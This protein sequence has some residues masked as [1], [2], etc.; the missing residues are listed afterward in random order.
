MKKV[1]LSFVLGV[2]FCFGAQAADLSIVFD[3]GTTA[4]TMQAK[5][6]K[7]QNQIGDWMKADLVRV[8]GRYAKA[9]ISAKLA[10][11]KEDAQKSDL[12]M[13]KIVSYSAGSKAARM[14]VGYGAGGVKLDIHYELIVDGKSLMSKDDG[15][16]SGRDWRNAARKL[17]EN[18]AKA[19]SQELKK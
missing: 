4:D 19:V 12:L 11:K 10:D 16:Y 3:N 13:V 14:L 17:N 2:L 18:L 1:L 5:Q 6:V 7:A 8:F 15:V 9:G